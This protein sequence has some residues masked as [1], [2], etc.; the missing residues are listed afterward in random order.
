MMQLHVLQHTDWMTPGLIQDWA[1]AH[2]IEL[3]IHRPDSGEN[4]TPLNANDIDGLIILD[5][6]FN[7]DDNERWVAAERILVRS[8]DKIGRPVFGIS[9]GAEQIARAFGAPVVPMNLPEFGRGEVNRADGS[10]LA[11][12]QWHQQAIVDLPGATVAYSNEAVAMQGFTYHHRIMGVQFHLECTRAIQQAYV[13]ASDF[14]ILPLLTDDE[15]AAAQQ[16]L[17]KLLGEVFL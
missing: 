15:Q 7:I 4:L 12:F 14:N 16:E 17:N 11:V 9:F 13:D 3:V 5:G 10:S 6:P 2:D 8:L 1:T